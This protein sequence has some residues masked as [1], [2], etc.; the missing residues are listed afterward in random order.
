MI[1][2]KLYEPTFTRQATHSLTRWWTS[3]IWMFFFCV[4]AINPAGLTSTPSTGILQNFMGGTGGG[5]PSR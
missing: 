3:R 4:C 1:H 2:A 5:R